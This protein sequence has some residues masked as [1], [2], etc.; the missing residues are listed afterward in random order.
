M[1]EIPTLAQFGITE[2]VFIRK[3]NNKNRW[4]QHSAEVE[5]REKKIAADV[6]DNEICSLWKVGSDEDFY[7]FVAAISSNRSF[8][9][10]N[11]DFIWMTQNDLDQA[12]IEYQKIPEGDC[13]AV[14]HLHYNTKITKSQAILLCSR[15]IERN[16]EPQRCRKKQTASILKYQQTKGCIAVT[17]NPPCQ[18][19]LC[20]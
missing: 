10:Q 8:Q 13:L 4:L 15:L 11:I 3:I 19:H 5:D 9:N 18:Y 20:S 17:K 2:S 6:F 16:Q 14:E 12:G 1:S 7:G